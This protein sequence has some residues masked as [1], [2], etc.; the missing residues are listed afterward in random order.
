M[1]GDAEVIQILNDVLCAELTAINQYFIH[2]MMCD[3]WG[4]K[5]L[6]KHVAGRVHR[7]DEARRRSVIDRILYLDGVPNMQ[8][9]MSVNVGQT[10]PEMHQFDL[11]SRRTRWPAS[12]PASSSAGPRATT[13]RACCSRRSCT[14]RRTTSTG[15]RRSST[16]I[17][18]TG[19]RRT[20]SR[21]SSK[22]RPT[23]AG[24]RQARTIAKRVEILRSAAAAFRRR[25]YHGA[26]VDEI[27]RT[28]R[29]TKGNLYYYFENKEEIL[30]FCH[31]YS[32]DILLDRLRERGEGGRRRPTRRLR[33]L[34]EAF[35][36]MIID[37]LHGTALTLD[38]QALSPAH[39][40][41]VIAKR[42]RFDRGRAPDRRGGDAR[43]A[44]SRPA[45]PSW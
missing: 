18:T 6:A 32:L 40:R 39:L 20:T 35:V 31:D 28:L 24:R 45:T 16:L 2:A 1:K 12:T 23:P 5:R 17:Q 44:P 33:R 37:E 34:I 8:K 11:S 14:K 27:A 15:W 21:S 30:F 4:F 13:A 3:N 25:G 42:D 10:V 38:L 7:G 9:Y 41:S 22:S 36:H 19:P 26:T 29:M 43:R